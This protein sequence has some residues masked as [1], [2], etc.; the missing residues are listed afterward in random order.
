MEKNT[1]LISPLYDMAD[2]V[3]SNDAKRGEVTYEI[4][5]TNGLPEDSH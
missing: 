2:L 4:D 1:Q 5:E 3:I